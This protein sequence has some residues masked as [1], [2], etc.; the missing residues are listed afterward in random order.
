MIIAFYSDEDV[1]DDVAG[2]NDDDDKISFQSD[3]ATLSSEINIKQK[4]ID[5]LEK[6]HK[7]VHLMKLQYEEKMK[8]LQVCIC[9]CN[10]WQLY[11][12]IY[13]YMQWV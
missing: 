2:N 6:S 12:V 1:S 7:T 11:Q 10:L 4:L 3:L 9:V 5:E 13:K 8:S